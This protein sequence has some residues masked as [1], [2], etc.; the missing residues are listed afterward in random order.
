MDFS[1][2]G[3]DALGGLNE[4]QREAVSAPDGPTLVLAGAGSGKTRVIVHRI[5]YLV[6]NRSVSPDAVLAVTFTNKAADEMRRRVQELLPR[7]AGDL[8][9]HTFHAL[10]LRLLR[11]FGEDVGLSRAFTVYGEEE[12]R[13]LL[14]RV[15]RE[16]GLAEREYPLSRVSASISAGKNQ[17]FSQRND[18]LVD[19]ALAKAAEAYQRELEA[20]GGVDFDD[21]LL[22][23]VE[24]LE[25][26]E[27]A[28]GYAARRFRQV[29]VDEYQDTNRVQYRLMRLLAPHGNLFVVGD[30][31]QSIYNFRGADLRNILDF[32]RDFA[33]ARVVKLE[34]NYRSTAAILRA[35]SAVIGHN[36]E[37]KGKTLVPSLPEGD[38]IELHEANDEREEAA[39]ACGIIERLR[40]RAPESRV[41]VLLRTHAQTRAFEE[42]LVRRNV[43]HQV[44]GGL[45]FY[46]RREVKDALAYLRLTHNPADDASFLRAVNVPPRGVGDATQALLGERARA[47]GVSL[48]EASEA[49]LDGDAVSGRARV[50][51]TGFRALIEGLSARLVV[52]KPSLTLKAIL[53]ESGL[54]ASLLTEGETA[55]RE[56]RENLDQLVASALEYEEGEKEP[57]LAGYLDRVSLLTDADTLETPAPCL[58]MTLHAAK[59]L[60]FDAV[61]LGGLEEGLFPHVR[62]AGDK[63]ALEEERRLFYVGLTRARSLLFLS[64]ARSRFLSY[65]S[66]FREPSRFLLE[67][68]EDALAS[69]VTASPKGGAASVPAPKDSF[70]PGTIVS[71][72]TF[73]EGRVLAATGSGRDRKV[74]VLFHKAGRKKLLLEYAGLRVLS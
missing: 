74:T 8:S 37:R 38:R 11:R 27:R 20:L 66:A 60:E 19:P 51:L 70:R 7:P 4:R 42:E 45:R 41:A 31:D 24:L 50:G 26:S 25:C 22:K 67:I 15:M 35:A 58:L 29:L 17:A 54:L 57:S 1:L 14:R 2:D 18:G 46:E 34:V 73:G 47:R 36:V 69:S 44:L 63:R 10:C 72:K 68:P 21:L 49:L 65:L 30:E 16:L 28:Q 43:P 9:I 52:E 12:R 33:G 56:R 3:V 64:Y 61:F 53:E 48:W 59:G 5:A 40:R 32:E 62:A 71:H 6:Q 55:A 23:G 39:H 13:A